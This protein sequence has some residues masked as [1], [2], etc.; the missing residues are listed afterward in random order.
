MSILLTSTGSV[1]GTPAS[2]FRTGAPSVSAPGSNRTAGMAGTTKA[3]SRAPISA[4]DRGAGNGSLPF[5]GEGF[6]RGGFRAVRG[7]GW[8]YEQGFWGVR[9]R[10][11]SQRPGDERKRP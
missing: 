9:L 6:H 1:S 2:R 8:G 3:K 11:N 4:P 7:L 5:K 10:T